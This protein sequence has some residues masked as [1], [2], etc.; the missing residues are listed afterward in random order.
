MEKNM[1]AIKKLSGATL[2][3]AAATLLLSGCNSTG[4][5]TDT[6]ATMDEADVKCG[7]IN[8]CKGTTACAT[9][10]NACKGQNSCKGSGWLHMNKS[11]CEAKGGKVLG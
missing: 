6:A 1:S 3:A 2:A 5:T 4:D 7:G 8:S 11:D 10:N 9:A